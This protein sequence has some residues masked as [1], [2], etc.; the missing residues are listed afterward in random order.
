M[1]IAHVSKDGRIQ[2]LQEH[3][4]NVRILCEN[5]GEKMN[6]KHTV[7][8]S[9]LLHD[10]GKYSER[11]Q[12]YLGQIAETGNSE[13]RNGGDHSVV[14]GMLLNE[15]CLSPQ[16]SRAFVPIINAIISHHGQLHD[17][18]DFMKNESDYEKR[19]SKDVE[20]Y[21]KMKQLFFD[22][23]LSRA[24]FED[25]LMK[26]EEEVNAYMKSYIQHFQSVGRKMSHKMNYFNYM[27]V[28][29]TKT[30][31]SCLLDADRL[32]SKWFDEGMKSVTTEV[33]WTLL[34]E[35]LDEK[36]RSFQV[37]N[38]IDTLRRDM[39]EQCFQKASGET[40]IYSLSIPTGGGKTLASLRFALEHLQQQHKKRIIYIVPYTTIIEQNVQ[41]VKNILWR[42]GEP[43]FILE[44]HSNVLNDNMSHWEKAKNRDELKYDAKNYV[45][46]WDAPIIFTTLVQY[47]NVFYDAKNRNTR[48]LHNLK[49]S[50]IIFDEVQAVPL[51]TIAL[52][53]E[54]LHFLTTFFNTTVMLCT[55]TQPALEKVTKSLTKPIELIENLHEVTEQFSRT[56]IEYLNE[57]GGYDTQQLTQLILE[58]V[59]RENNV[60]TIVNTKAVARKVMKHL[61]SLVNE[62]E[63]SIYHLSTSMCPA[64]RRDMLE[65][66]K[67]CLEEGRKV[68]CIATQLIE[69]GVDISFNCV[70]RSLAG[71][72]SI[73]QAA[74]RCNRHG[75]SNTKTVYVVKVNE[76]NLSHLKEIAD[77]AR[78]ADEL[79]RDCKRTNKNPLGQE[80][81][82]LYFEKLFQH[83]AYELEFPF[84]NTT[85]YKLFFKGFEK[86]SAY[87]Y[88]N[89]IGRASKEFEV[90]SSES[91]SLLVPYDSKV[92]SGKALINLLLSNETI[93]DFSNVMKQA[94][95]FSITIFKH[96]RSALEKAGA[97]T[98]V[99]FGKRHLLVLNENSYSEKYGLDLEGNHL[100][101]ELY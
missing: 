86:P 97:I 19:L 3:L 17:M 101:H 41:E 79:L 75:R 2:S 49:D 85:L 82:T 4:H 9:G 84:D 61:E 16:K 59:E 63:C 22:D 72:S 52:F 58:K 94:Q 24:Q 15:Y 20:D 13:F 42:E 37:E 68:I 29:L 83:Y 80:M 74:G 46:N 76:E 60:L 77:G 62:K 70:I 57:P 33:D 10:M 64:H 25:Y 67:K 47:L 6:L 36:L 54:S 53:N 31:F 56:Q 90:I 73:A 11:F 89:S 38:S 78:F 1:N 7:G 88:S 27:S 96:E 55:A 30:I 5:Y 39:S 99:T 18:E 32:D 91:E 87:F 45:D 28:F 40:A 66:V 21:E 50:I 93:D 35:R 95:Q 92:N 26:V 100:N 43:S 14:G 48:R 12:T 69:A 71:L 8:L 65:H 44:H 34:Q 81:M 98:V 23:V 51:R